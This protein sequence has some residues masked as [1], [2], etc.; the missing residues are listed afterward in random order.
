MAV[1]QAPKA[2]QRKGLTAS[3]WLYREYVVAKRGRNWRRL[4]SAEEGLVRICIHACGSLRPF[5]SPPTPPEGV[6]LSRRYKN[7]R[8][9]FDRI[10]DRRQFAEEFVRWELRRVMSDA[11][12]QHIARRCKLRLIDQIRSDT[13]RERG[14]GRKS[15]DEYKAALQKVKHLQCG[16]KLWQYIKHSCPEWRDSTNASIAR[17]WYRSEAWIRKLRKRLATHLWPLAENDE[18]RKALA[19]LRLKPTGVCRQSK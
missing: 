14:F 6:E 13:R 8:F 4:K 15:S 1:L 2:K 12:G 18:Q 5:W 19:L 17:D 11:E 10:G 9:R 3:Q 16:E 7:F